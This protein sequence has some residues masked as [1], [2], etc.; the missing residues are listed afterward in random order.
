M[1]VALQAHTAAS[2]RGTGRLSP[3]YYTCCSSL[4]SGYTACSLSLVLGDPRSPS[5]VTSGNHPSYQ[6][7]A[8]M[9]ALLARAFG[10]T[11]GLRKAYLPQAR[12]PNAQK[13]ACTAP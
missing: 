13:H 3:S 6:S 11:L 10:R 12:H 9:L 7:W 8:I 2:D 5:K 1:V 4:A